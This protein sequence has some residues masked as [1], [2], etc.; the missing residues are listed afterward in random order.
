MAQHLPQIAVSP[1][2]VWKYIAAASFIH[3]CDEA[4]EA[5]GTLNGSKFVTTSQHIR[6]IS[7]VKEIKSGFLLH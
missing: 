6:R 2:A 7:R 5:Q 3:G 1:V 4:G